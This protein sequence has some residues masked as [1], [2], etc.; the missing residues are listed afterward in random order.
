MN[1]VPTSFFSELRNQSIFSLIAP[2]LLF[3]HAILVD[4]TFLSACYAVLLIVVLAYRQSAFSWSLWL[5]A[6]GCMAYAFLYLDPLPNSHMA[7][8][9][10]YGFIMLF[11]GSTANK[12]E[13]RDAVIHWSSLLLLLS[14]FAAS[15]V[16]YL[17][18]ETI[19]S[20]DAMTFMIVTGKTL[21]T[22]S[23]FIS[24]LSFNT[25]DWQEVTSIFGGNN[26]AI[27]MFENAI[28]MLNAELDTNEN[29][30][31][32]AIGFTWLL[33]TLQGVIALS[34]CLWALTAKPRYGSFAHLGLIFYIIL[35]YGDATLALTATVLCLFGIGLTQHDSLS[36][37]RWVYLLMIAGFLLL[38]IT[39]QEPAEVASIL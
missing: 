18:N 5:A 19:R 26:M 35:S 23:P 12:D 8:L 34:L 7:L 22:F 25:A 2:I 27:F 31:G 32:F 17:S 37:Y 24:T 30:H 9:S 39:S 10:A 15:F 1:I 36:K 16:W 11:I 28:E 6:L 4:S 21:T 20:G 38:G 13:Q 29:L 33:I 3:I 14:I